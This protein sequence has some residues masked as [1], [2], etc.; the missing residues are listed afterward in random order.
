[1]DTHFPGE[2]AEYSGNFAFFLFTLT[3]LANFKYKNKSRKP[4]RRKNA[5]GMISDEYP[6]SYPPKPLKTGSAPPFGEG[7]D[8]SV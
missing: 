7:S 2:G 5:A 3:H 4:R 8:S 1:M 6:I